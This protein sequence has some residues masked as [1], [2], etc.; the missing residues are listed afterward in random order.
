MPK[1]YSSNLTEL[2]NVTCKPPRSPSCQ[3]KEGRGMYKFNFLD[4]LL[5]PANALYHSITDVMG[6]EWPKSEG[7]VFK[8]RERAA[9]AA[10]HCESTT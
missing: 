8:R 2:G 7:T 9:A 6:Q 1:D 10:G 5:G 4:W 3:E